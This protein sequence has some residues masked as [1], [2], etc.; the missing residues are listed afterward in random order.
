VII[1]DKLS[2]EETQKLV[3]T[4]EK[5]WSVIGHSL[6]D[7]KGITPSLCTHHIPMDQ[8][9]KPIQKYQ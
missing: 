8:D 4:L 9:N 1:S 2:H 5:F 3:A 6:K 7:L